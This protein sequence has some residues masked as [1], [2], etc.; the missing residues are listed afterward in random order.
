MSKELGVSYSAVYWLERLVPVFHT[1]FKFI[2]TLISL[3]IF[4]S[5]LIEV[6]EYKR[7]DLCNIGISDK[8]SNILLYNIRP[9]IA[10]FALFGRTVAAAFLYFC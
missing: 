5:P 4:K 3:E 8:V 6:C 1:A 2:L 10:L 9:A 7:G